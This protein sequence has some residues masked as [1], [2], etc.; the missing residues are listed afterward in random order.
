MDIKQSHLSHKWSSYHEVVH[1][2]CLV[3]YIFVFD[4]KVIVHSPVLCYSCP[5][6]AMIWAQTYRVRG[7]VCL[8]GCSFSEKSLC[9]SIS[10]AR[11][12]LST[13]LHNGSLVGWWWCSY[14][15]C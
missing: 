10:Q 7:F 15:Y 1:A 3:F 13:G 9:A 4:N 2:M 8:V 6:N 14:R 11:E 12:L 5:V